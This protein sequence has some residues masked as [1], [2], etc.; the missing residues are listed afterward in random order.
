M[1]KVGIM[2]IEA[3]KLELMR[4]L[5]QTQK[6]SLLLKLKEVFDDEKVD[7]W[8][9]M[10]KEEQEEIKIGLSQAEKGDYTDSDVVMKRFDKW[11]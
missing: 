2:N 4:L 11:H 7:W 8:V 6:E 9:E 3:T 1:T 10:S 5:L